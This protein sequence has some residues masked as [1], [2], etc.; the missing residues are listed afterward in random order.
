M[1]VALS[2]PPGRGVG[3]KTGWLREERNPG[4]GLTL[5]PNLAT[6]SEESVAIRS[7]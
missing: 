2:R 6:G 7:V 3:R 4:G 1:E 5:T